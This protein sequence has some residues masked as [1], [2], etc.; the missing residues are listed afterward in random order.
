MAQKITTSTLRFLFNL[1]KSSPKLLGLMVTTQ[2]VFAVLTTTIAPL[3]VSH[4]LISITNSTATLQSSSWLLLG[5]GLVLFVGDVIAIRVSIALAFISETK[6]QSDTAKRILQHLTAKSLGYHADRMTGGTISDATKLN[7]SIERFW[8]T[9]MFT[10]IP[11]ITTIISVC[12]ALAFIF[13][14]YSL[15][16]FTLSLV[17]ISLIVRAQSAI[18]PTSRKVAETSSAMTAHLADVI[19]NIGIVKAFAQ[20]DN[21]LRMFTKRVDNW[22]NATKA[23]MKKVLIVTGSF[24]IM[25]TILNISAFLAAIIA[26]TYHVASVGAIYLVISYTLSVVM[27]LWSV[28]NVTRNYIR[29]IGDATPMI[30]ALN[31]DI[32]L[33]DPTEPEASRISEGKILFDNITFAHDKSDDALFHNFS[34]VINPGERV[35][36]VGHSGSGKTSLTRI[37]LR[38]S[39]VEAGNIII[40]GQVITA[41]TQRDLHRTIAYVPQEPLLFHRTLRENIAY[42]KPDASDASILKA[43]KLANALDFIT[44]LPDGLDT[45]VGERGVKLS[46]GQRQ[47]I[48]IARAI[49]K[50]APILV[51]DEATSALDSE[52]EKLIQDALEKLMKGRTSIVIAHRLSTIATLDRIIVLDN[53]NIVED[54]S[55]QD[56][57]KQ[58]GTYASLWAHQSGGFFEE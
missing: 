57:L 20:E 49:L 54:G 1:R 21:E 45:T 37:L 44:K 55:H 43:A 5:Y 13:W 56:L 41:I 8:D 12:I 40:D 18:A 4:L 2:I 31:E 53:G 15:V 7:G 9:V 19:G 33:H 38:F 46:G 22:Q 24:G 26:T 6:M 47:R 10:G 52:S 50:D 30:T 27:Q 32:E 14:Q 58:K 51:L 11:I 29:I 28:S 25:M 42:G 35:G 23:E 16:L 34:L 3:F 36:V 39:D 17:V 48:A